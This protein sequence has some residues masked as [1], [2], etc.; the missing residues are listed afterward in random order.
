MRHAI[1]NLFGVLTREQLVRIAPD[2]FR[3]VRADDADR[4]DHG[5][6]GP[7]ARSP[8]WSL[9][10][11]SAGDAERRFVRRLAVMPALGLPTGMASSQPGGSS[12]RA[13]STP[14]M[15]ITYSCAFS[16]RLSFTRTAG[17]T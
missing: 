14:F 8:H 11:Q 9:R 12:K 3:K 7:A 10:I 16:E 5:I 17:S 2:E 15:Q 6:A 4:V 13:I 1:E